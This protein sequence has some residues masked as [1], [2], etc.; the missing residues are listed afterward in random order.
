MPASEKFSQAKPLM[1]FKALRLATML[2]ICY[3]AL[4]ACSFRVSPSIH[5]SPS[6]QSQSTTEPDT[7]ALKQTH[8]IEYLCD[9][10][11]ELSIEYYDRKLNRK[12]G[13]SGANL[14]YKSESQV[15]EFEMYSTRADEGE[16]Y[17]TEQGL[18]A[19]DGLMWWV[20]NN[21]EQRSEGKLITMILEDTANSADYP[22][23]AQCEARDS[24]TASRL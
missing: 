11:S 14:R 16:K 15:Q 13:K 2:T 19:E 23:I 6:I 8:R 9:N 21:D 1:C 3:A 7:K 5:V 17:A 10:Q 24:I 18:N 12:D 22:V 20:Y 4:S